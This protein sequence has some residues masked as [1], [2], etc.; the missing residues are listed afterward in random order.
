M[1]E[2]KRIIEINGVK[3]EV[4]LRNA[5]E[6]VNYKV[7][8]QVKVLTKTYSGYESHIG[9]II[10]FDDYKETPTIV[11]AYLD[12]SSTS[13]SIKFV[14]Y[15]KGVEDVELTKLNDWDLPVTKN[16]IVTAFQK[17]E[18][19]LKRDLKDLENKRTIFEKLFGK[20]FETVEKGE[21]IA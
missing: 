12:A 8:D 5:T 17:E 13:A 3:M 19:Q 20:Y 14:H 2:T 11:I 15:N 21:G 9:T 1:D 7:G 6:I 16:E 4:D 18:E 10:A